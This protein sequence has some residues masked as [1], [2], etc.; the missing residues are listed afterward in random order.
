M[1]AFQTDRSR[2]QRFVSGITMFAVGMPDGLVV[3][4]LWRLIRLILF[5][6]VFTAGDRRC[7][8]G[9]DRIDSD[10]WRESSDPAVV[11]ASRLG[12]GRPA[13]QL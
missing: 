9:T 11:A 10:R 2:W 4:R 6:A 3:L 5:N 12:H 13:G 1:K 7:T 8:G